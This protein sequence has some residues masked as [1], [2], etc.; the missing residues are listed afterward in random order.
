MRRRDWFAAYAKAIAERDLPDIANVERAADLPG[1]L[2]MLAALN[3]QPVNATE[4]GGRLQIDRKTAQRYLALAEQI[5]VVR[6]LP[7]W[8]GN[9]VK[10]LTKAPKSHFVDS[11]LAPMLARVTAAHLGADKTPPGHLLESFV[12]AELDKQCGRSEG[13]YFRDLN[14]SEVPIVVEDGSG[15]VAGIEV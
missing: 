10:R 8:S 12:L 9:A 15:R 5:L 3:G 4:L 13:R 6:T 2:R 14:G 7:A 11:G 1:F